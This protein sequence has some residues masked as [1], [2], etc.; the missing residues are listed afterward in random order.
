MFMACNNR[1]RIV[2]KSQLLGYDYRLF[3]NTPAWDLAKAVEDEDIAMIVEEVEVKGIDPNFREPKFGSTLLMLSI[4]NN[5]YESVKTLLEL[6]ADPNLG[7]HYRGASAMRNAALAESPKYLQLLLSY[8]GNPNA[9]ETAPTKE[10][11]YSRKTALISAISYIEDRSLEKVKLL[12]DAGA[13]INYYKENHTSLPLSDAIKF[14]KMD[15]ALYLLEKGA[16]YNRFMYKMSDG[17]KIYILEALKHNMYDIG[18]RKH[19]TKMEIV[20]FLK[21]RGLDYWNEPIPE[22]VIKEIKNK[23]SKDWENYIKRY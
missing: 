10:G 16:D 15:V 5:N 1:E 22:R 3:Q 6:G 12:V 20:D 19:R 2:D 11:D 17:E 4:R 23:Y 9:I 7:D 13:D 8:N 21:K 14:D 18:S